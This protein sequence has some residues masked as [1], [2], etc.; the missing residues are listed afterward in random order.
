MRRVM[1]LLCGVAL[2]ACTPRLDP[3]GPVPGAERFA[4]VEAEGVRLW[5]SGSSWD[6]QPA[7]LEEFLTPVLVTI[8]NVS[9]R[10]LRLTPADLTLV[11]S[12]GMHYAALPPLKADVRSE[13]GLE[14]QV[15]LA[16]YHRAVPVRPAPR[17]HPGHAPPPKRFWV[18]R[19]WVPFHVGVPLWPAPWPWWSV[20]WHTTHYAQWPVPLPSDDMIRRALPEGVLD[21]GG[22]VS[23]FVYFPQLGARERTVKLELKLA[24]ATTGTE[25]GVARVQFLV[26]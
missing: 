14:G 24:D 4:F 21:D 12:S 8:E 2:F 20:H 17:P 11:G 25:W 9:G 10:Q 6:G 18:V 7:N 1:T 3:V 13:L 26:R 22:T 23:G 5:A 16:D 19:P 15:V